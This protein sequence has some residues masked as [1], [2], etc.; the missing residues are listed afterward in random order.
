[1]GFMEKKIKMQDIN[2]EVSTGTMIYVDIDV[3]RFLYHE[4]I[5]CLTIQI[6]NDGEYEF[7]EEVDLPEGEVIVNHDDFKKAAIKW[8]FDNVKITNEVACTK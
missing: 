7:L 6:E 1:M 2:L 8:L 4:E 3:F 5:F